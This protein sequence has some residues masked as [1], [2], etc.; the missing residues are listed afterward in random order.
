[1]F[2]IQ[3]DLEPEKKI[4]KTESPP[5]K[6]HK[7]IH[8]FFGGKKK[9]PE[10]KNGSEEQE[11]KSNTEPSS[12]KHKDDVEEELNTE[13]DETML[14]SDEEPLP[15][16]DDVVE[17][18]K[19]K[20][21]LEM[22]EDFYEFW[23][24][25]CHLNS[26]KP[27]EA[28]HDALG[29]QLVGPFD[30]LAG[31]HKGVMKNKHG[32]KPNFLLHW[33]YYYDPPE[34]M[35]VIKGDN[36]SQFHIGYL[37]DDPSDMPVMVASNS[38]AESCSIVPKGDNLFAAIKNCID[39]HMKAKGT[40]G[41][42]KKKLQNLEDEVVAWA[43]KKNFSLDLKS[44]KMKDR[45]KKVV[46]KTFHGA[47]IVVPV[48]AIN[49]IGYR[50]VPETPSDLKK[51]FK[52]VVDSKTDKERDENMDPVQE[53]ITLVQFANDECDYGEGLELGMDLFCYGGKVFHPMIEH[54]LPLAYQLLG[55]IEYEQ[56]IKAH[57][58]HRQKGADLS[59]LD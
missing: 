38:A 36:S 54:L 31:R 8:D 13:E 21:L 51:M 50:P 10:S 37:R 5:E 56:I 29:Y 41:T 17:N 1:M 52:K 25:C 23:E 43:K 48:D 42:K 12:S 57:L 53:L 30:I 47:G 55:R 15:S 3:V 34:F 35:T 4:K 20:Y 59:Q 19:R 58:L 39:E 7:T 40:D 2:N 18:I 28:L 45:D 49:D 33:R 44:K 6:Q 11:H 27:R 24:F 14:D 16:P 26:K 22:P 32:R 46:C 9:E